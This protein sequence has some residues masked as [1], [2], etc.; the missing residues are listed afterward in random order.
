[1]RNPTWKRDELILELD[2]YFRH[3]P[4][5]ISQTHPAAV[6]LSRILNALP[7][8]GHRPDAKRFRNPNGVYMKLCNFLRLDPEYKG[9]GLRAG[10]K[11]D[12]G[13]WSEFASERKRLAK[14]AAGFRARAV[15]KGKEEA[16]GVA[17][18]EE[19]EFPEGRV[20]F[21]AHRSR[22]RPEGCPVTTSLT[23]D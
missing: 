10:G 12:V 22:E 15:H 11:A 9:K 19:D 18:E 5:H 2:L 4:S 23:L 7:I 21:R 14:T 6:E 16:T 1:M 20:L 17:V 8:H 13:V 3:Q